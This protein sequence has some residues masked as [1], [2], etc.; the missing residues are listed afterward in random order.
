MTTSLS[1]QVYIPKFDIQGHRGAR[2]L[3]PENT[4]PAFLT[5]LDSGVTT[6]ELDVVITKDKEVIVSHEPWMSAAICSDPSGKP[7]SEKE[8][9]KYNM[10]KMSYGQIK[11]F[12]CGSRGNARF[13]EQEKI[14]V[15]KPLLSEVIIA[16]ENHIK[17]FTR[18]EVDYNIEIK[19]EK[20]LDGKFQPAPEGFSDLVYNLINQYLPLERIV[21]QSF[22]FR[23]LKYWHEKYPQVRLAALVENLNTIDENMKEL[24]FTPS[25]YSP[26]YKLLSKWEVKYCHELN[27][28]VIPWTVNDPEEMLALM[29]MGV[30]GFIT[31]YP[32][33]AAKFKRTLNIKS[34]SKPGK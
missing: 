13:P 20:E 4:I 31:D 19:S 2:G 18:Y 28:R 3:K 27:M 29:G 9:K 26:D 8:E 14:A 22:D 11:Q 30:D 7:V 33:R 5:A 1:A 32:D 23:V 10:Y 6:L 16:A 34:T 17:N 15:F 25:I 12:D 21:I 24:G